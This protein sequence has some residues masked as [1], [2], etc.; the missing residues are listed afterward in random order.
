[1]K[2]STIILQ[3]QGYY[4]LKGMGEGEKIRGKKLKEKY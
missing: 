4:C 1:M 2:I 3:L